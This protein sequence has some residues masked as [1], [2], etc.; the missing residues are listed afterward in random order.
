M[1]NRYQILNASF[2]VDG[3]LIGGVSFKDAK[4]E[5]IKALQSQI[6]DVEALT[7]EQYDRAKKQGFH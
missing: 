6:N 3:Y 5:V 2:K 4:K 1:D 7:E